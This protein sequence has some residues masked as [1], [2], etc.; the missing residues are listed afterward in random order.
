MLLE[1]TMRLAPAASYSERQDSAAR[2][3]NELCKSR[4]LAG[5]STK[6]I[7]QSGLEIPVIGDVKKTVF[8]N[9]NYYVL[10]TSNEHDP[11]LISVFGKSDEEP[12]QAYLV[13]WNVPEFSSRLENAMRGRLDGWLHGHF[14]VM[15]FDPYAVGKY[16]AFDPGF[17]KDFKFAYQ[18]EYRFVWMP[19]SL[20]D[21]AEEP[22]F[23]TTGSLVDIATL[24]RADGRVLAGVDPAE[25][26]QRC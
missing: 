16:D 23:T 4:Y 7:T 15:Y 25:S 21:C 10:C 9:N 20:N 17:S 12:A 3:D 13:I 11:R 22:I 5:G 26:I 8:A 1:G 18:R 14:T 6:I 2:S 24:F 19:Q